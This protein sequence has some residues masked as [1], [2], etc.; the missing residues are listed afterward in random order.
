MPAF[1]DG[2]RVSRG[3]S[4][5]R[6]SGFA[7]LLLIVVAA[8]LTRIGSECRA[9]ERA[10]PA[11]KPA[12]AQ[13]PVWLGTMD[14]GVRVFRFA[15]EEAKNEQ[16]MPVHQL[17]SFDE[18][19][20]K[21]VLDKFLL[22]DQMLSF[23]LKATRAAYRGVRDKDG[24]RIIGKWKQSGAEFDLEF[25]F[26]KQ[27]QPKMPSEVWS[28]QINPLLQK[29]T[30]QFRVYKD[31]AGVESV[32]M[33]SVSQKAGGFKATRILDGGKWT[34]DVP[35]LKGA[36][37]GEFNE[38]KSKVTGQ[39]SQGGLKLDLILE[40]KKDAEKSAVVVR[41]RPQTPTPPFPYTIE[42]V[43]VTNAADQVTLAGTL[44][45]PEGTNKVPAVVLISG[46]GPQDR[47][48]SLLEHKP[49][50]VL[51]DVLSRNGIA[52]LRYDDRGTA[53]ST[54]D[55]AVATSEDF[56]RDAEAAFDFLKLHPRVRT[57]KIGLMGH[58]EGGLIAPMVAARRNDVAFVVLLAGTGVNGREILLSQGQL[59]MKAEGITGEAELSG[60]R[61]VQT[62]LMDLV[63]RNTGTQISDEQIAA[64][65]KKLASQVPA[66]SQD[67]AQLEDVLRSGIE[68]L[69]SPWFRFFLSYEPVP[70]LESLTC[71]VLALNGEKD[72]QVDPTLNLPPIRK[73]LQ[74]AGNSKSE[75]LE[76]PSLN[77][78]FQT[79]RTGA[80]SEYIEIEE[81][82][83]PVVT[84][85]IVE[86]IAGVG[87]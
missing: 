66:D 84:Q 5:G 13:Q 73:A 25:E 28:G 27:L 63:T 61:E 2:P 7:L 71:P 56:S 79:C 54:G 50:A 1:H 3:G 81:T 68:T 32:L 16:G 55:H 23:E 38:S 62:M 86:W 37:T 69:Q 18:G 52:V 74:S 77:H 22:D 12:V 10:R 51:A 39:W 48:E 4:P 29:L 14:V 33:D 30:L 67:P 70:V 9:D 53:A 21:F 36:F 85:K 65:A 60:Q 82:I 43:V 6:S 42:D 17:I 34:I 8:G 49:F 87:E 76:L 24:T 20:Q 40:R 58:S 31:D 35:A 15:I 64:A 45:V 41:K 59:I 46:S 75:I 11:E 80:I 83:A 47:D 44:T 72:L 57:D 78:L 26:Q 19:E